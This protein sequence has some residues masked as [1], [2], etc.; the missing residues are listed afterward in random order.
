[1]NFGCGSVVNLLDFT[2]TDYV[3][4]R[5]RVNT[6]L[7]LLIAYILSLSDYL[8]CCVMVYARNYITFTLFLGSFSLRK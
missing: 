3:M 7:P 8:F 6:G 2:R 1:M 4:N 5:Y